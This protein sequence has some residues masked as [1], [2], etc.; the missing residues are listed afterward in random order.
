MMFLL[1]VSLAVASTSRVIGQ[2][3]ACD[4]HDL[5]AL[6]IRQNQFRTTSDQQASELFTEMYELSSETSERIGKLNTTIENTNANAFQSVMELNTTIKDL[7]SKVNL[8]KRELNTSDQVS[9][10]QIDTLVLQVQDIYTRANYLNF[11]LE[12]IRLEIDKIHLAIGKIKGLTQCPDGWV[13]Y[14][15]SCYLFSESGKSFQDAAKTCSDLG[16]HLVYIDSEAENNF[17]KNFLATL[18]GNA[19][20]IGL[21]DEDKEGTWTLYGTKIPATFFDW[22]EGEPNQSGEE[23][24]AHFW[25]R[26]SFKW[27]DEDCW[28]P[29]FFVCEKGYDT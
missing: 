8:W 28:F 15:K 24:C 19:Y 2:S 16:S 22:M 21:S 29:Y 23:D 18:K 27:N 25:D 1:I 6:M 17:L 7:I 20:W 14:N 26:F 3:I 13:F 9:G 5:R 10:E 11:F 4:K 12:E